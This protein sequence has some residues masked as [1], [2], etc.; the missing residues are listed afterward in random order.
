M[1]SVGDMFLA[2]EPRFFLHGLISFLIGHLFYIAL[3]Y[4]HRAE[5]MT[6]GHKGIAVIFALYGIALVGW[7]Y[8]SLGPMTAPVIV[9]AAVLLGMGVAARFADFGSPIVFGGALLFIASDSAIAINKFHLPIEG[10]GYFIWIAYYLAQLAIT[11]GVAKHLTARGN[12]EA[13]DEVA[14]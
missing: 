13:K 3:F 11:L 10:I 5:V 4:R 1:S 9:Y 2:L 14:Q 6:A 12:D 8:P 7:M